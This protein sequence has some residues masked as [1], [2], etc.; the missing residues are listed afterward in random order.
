MALFPITIFLVIQYHWLILTKIL[1]SWW[2]LLSDS[3]SISGLLS[4]RLLDCLL[5]S[6]DVLSVDLDFMLTLY[7]IHIRPLLEF[8][9]CVWNTGFLGHL[10]MLESI[11]RSWT[12]QI[13]AMSELSYSERLYTLDLCSVQGR[14]LW[15][16]LLKY[17][18]IFH[19]DCA[20]SP[21]DMFNLVLP[22][23]TRSHRFKIF[24]T[25]SSLEARRRFFSLRCVT[26]WNSFPN[27]VVALEF[28]FP[29]KSALHHTLGPVLYQ[30]VE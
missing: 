5:I 30:Y 6:S 7:K 22:L 26:L 19:R 29:F 27:E 23:G 12:R 25:H 4:I 11:Q 3:T 13:D 1:V 20:I 24:H 17:R 15:A 16:D 9:S 28:I 8:A 2:T 14:L 18:K 10:R 21:D